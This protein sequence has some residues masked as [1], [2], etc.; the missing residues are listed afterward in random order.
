VDVSH[1]VFDVFMPE[2]LLDVERVSCSPGFHCSS[3]VAKRFE[4]YV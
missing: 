2:E 4:A 3:E 1:G